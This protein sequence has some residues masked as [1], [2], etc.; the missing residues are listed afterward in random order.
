M[1]STFDR[2]QRKHPDVRA[3]PFGVMAVF[4]YTSDEWGRARER[5]FR[6]HPRVCERCGSS[7]DI[8]LHHKRGLRCDDLEALCGECHA[9]HHG[10]PEL[11]HGRGK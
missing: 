2:W 7:N 5:Y 9:K 11:D 8:Q 6:E 3:L 1:T 10:K 4:F